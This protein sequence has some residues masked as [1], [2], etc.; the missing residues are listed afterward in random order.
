M[1]PHCATAG[2]LQALGAVALFK[3]GQAKARME[4]LVYGTL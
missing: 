1:N 4:T 2:R 3:T